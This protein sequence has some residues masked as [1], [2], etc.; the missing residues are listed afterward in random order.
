MAHTQPLFIGEIRVRASCPGKKHIP[1]PN[2][3]IILVSQR[4]NIKGLQII[5]DM[6]FNHGKIVSVDSKE[7]IAEAAAKKFNKIL[8]VGSNREIKTLISCLLIMF[9]VTLT[10]RLFIPKAAGS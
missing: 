6:V 4:K 9:K 3:V 8:V 10:G 2:E 1:S 7:S 5:A